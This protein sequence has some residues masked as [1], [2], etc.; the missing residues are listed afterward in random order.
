MASQRGQLNSKRTLKRFRVHSIQGPVKRGM[1]DQFH[2][3]RMKLELDPGEPYQKE[4]GQVIVRF[5]ETQYRALVRGNPEQ[6]PYRDQAR[7][8]VMYY[9]I[10]KLRTI[11]GLPGA[12]TQ[13]SYQATQDELNELRAIDPDRVNIRD[14]IEIED[15]AALHKDRVFISCGQRSP[16]EIGLGEAIAQL[17]DETTSLKGYFAQNQQSLDGVT[18]NIFQALYNSA[19]FIAVMHRRDEL[20]R[21]DGVYRGSVW[22]EQEIA[23]AAFLVQVLGASFPNRVFIQSGIRREGVRGFILLNAVEFENNDEVL[24]NLGNWLVGLEVNGAPS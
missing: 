5:F 7:R 17:V 13:Y 20:A 24:T 15:Q 3:Y 1:L 19:A 4:E 11:L 23:I 6:Q 12:N 10:G 22:V 8:L 14:W 9:A 18:R 2:D 16:D 21:G